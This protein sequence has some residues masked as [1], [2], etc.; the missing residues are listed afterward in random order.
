[1]F[2]RTLWQRHMSS[3]NKG[4]VACEALCVAEAVDI[5]ADDPVLVDSDSEWDYEERPLA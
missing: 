1:M 2:P 3:P 5:L 4:S